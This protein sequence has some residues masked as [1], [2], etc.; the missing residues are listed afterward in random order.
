VTLLQRIF[1]YLSIPV[2]SLLFGSYLG[3][4]GY[5][6]SVRAGL[7]CREAEALLARSSLPAGGVALNSTPFLPILLLASEAIG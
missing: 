1:A 4:G 2:V 3:Y 6:E 5:Y 7:T